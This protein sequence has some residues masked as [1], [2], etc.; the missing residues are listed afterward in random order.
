MFS[1]NIYHVQP[2]RLIME[3]YVYAA[4]ALVITLL[5]LVFGVMGTT[6]LV[7]CDWLGMQSLTTC[8]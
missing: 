4:I 5:F 7:F 2:R 6:S 3:Q 1:V 8:Q